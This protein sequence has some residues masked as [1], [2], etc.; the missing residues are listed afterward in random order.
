MWGML[1]LFLPVGYN[2]KYITVMTSMKKF[3]FL[4]L[5]L[6]SFS[7]SVVL[8]AVFD[9]NLEYGMV[10][11]D[12]QTLQK[13]L[14]TTSFVVA[15]SGGGSPG[16]ETTKFGM[17]TRKALASFQESHN[18]TPAVG[19]FGPKTRAYVNAILDATPDLSTTTASSSSRNN[20][21]ENPAMG[22][23]ISALESEIKLLRAEIESARD[24]AARSAAG[25]FAAIALT[26]RINQL[27]NTTLTTPTISG[28]TITNATISGGSF[29]GSTISGTTLSASSGTFSGDLTVSGTATSTFAGNLSV[30]Q[31]SS[32]GTII[33][34]TLDQGT[35]ASTVQGLTAKSTPGSTDLYPLV[36]M[37]GTP[38]GKKI[39]DANVGM[40][41]CVAGYTRVAPHFCL[42]SSGGVYVATFAPT[43]NGSS[44]V[45]SFDLTDY[46]E[47]AAGVARYLW[48][49]GRMKMNTTGTSGI[50]SNLFFETHYDAAGTKGAGRSQS[51]LYEWATVTANTRIRN[52]TVNF[53]APLVGNTM[54]YK[55]Y[56]DSGLYSSL[57]AMEQVFI[58]GYWD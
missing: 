39:T 2:S 23:T 17:A 38:T 40:E 11:T 19:Y 53:V 10:A 20:T 5:F 28:G 15:Q 18:I 29:S 44:A 4:T 27:T 56:H 16:N 31:Y 8:A 51:S 30:S 32:L 50:Y 35:V 52:D 6:A 41:A 13:F 37:S 1:L 45:R 54:Y 7:P 12:V 55:L 57:N 25:N 36:D 34:S 21:G 22:M 9:R 43:D 3:L 46:L 48:M 42:A 49:S 14:N 26:N 58:R 24:E 47:D 33:G